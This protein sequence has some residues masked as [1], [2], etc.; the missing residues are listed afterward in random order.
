MTLTAARSKKS[1]VSEKWLTLSVHFLTFVICVRHTTG[2]YCEQNVENVLKDVSAG[3]F[4]CSFS[5]NRST[6]LRD[7]QF[8]DVSTAET[9]RGRKIR[10]NILRSI[11]A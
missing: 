7:L 11:S 2:T 10:E 6:L 4:V 9:V 5:M 1:T 8:G 3:H